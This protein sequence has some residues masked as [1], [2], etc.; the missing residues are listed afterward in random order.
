MHEGP[1]PLSDLQQPDKKQSDGDLNLP[2]GLKISQFLIR[3]RVAWQG[4]WPAERQKGALTL[5]S[6]RAKDHS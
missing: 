1:Q 5:K 3:A 4:T 2:V 6:A